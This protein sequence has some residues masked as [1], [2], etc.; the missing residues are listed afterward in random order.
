MDIDVDI[1]MDAYMESNIDIHIMMDTD[2]KVDME[3][4]TD[5]ELGSVFRV[6]YIMLNNRCEAVVVWLEHVFNHVWEWGGIFYHL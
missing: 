4:D 1:C 5:M 2:L 6:F 3:M